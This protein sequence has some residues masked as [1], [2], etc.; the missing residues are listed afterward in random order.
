[1]TSLEI[2]GYLGSILLAACGWPLAF[3]ALQKGRTVMGNELSTRVFMWIWFW[4]EFFTMTYVGGKIGLDPVLF[5]DYTLNIAA[6]T[7]VLYFIYFPRSDNE[8]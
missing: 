5:L 4:G 3:D 2:I 1:M 6:V 7:I 8:D